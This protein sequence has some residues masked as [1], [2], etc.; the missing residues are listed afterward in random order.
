MGVFE[1]RD[2]EVIPRDGDIYNKNMTIYGYSTFRY[3]HKEC[4]DVLVGDDW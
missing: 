4:I 2:G 1:W 3:N